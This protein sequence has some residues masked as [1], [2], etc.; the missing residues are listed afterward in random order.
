[1]H[2]SEFKRKFCKMIEATEHPL[3]PIILQYAYSNIGHLATLLAA[4]GSTKVETEQLTERFLRD[5]SD[6]QLE[7]LSARPA[8]IIALCSLLAASIESYR[9]TL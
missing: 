6:D 2:G 7:A 8:F 3:A 4:P 1:M 9:D 5:F